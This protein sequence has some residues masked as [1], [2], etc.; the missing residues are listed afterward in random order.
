MAS[1]ESQAFNDRPLYTAFGQERPAL[2]YLSSRDI[3]LMFKGM[4]GDARSTSRA[5]VFEYWAG[6]FLGRGTNQIRNDDEAFLYAAR[7][8]AHLFGVPDGAENESDLARNQTLRWAT[9]AGV[10][11]NCDDRGQWNRGFTAD[12]EVRYRGLFAAASF[13]WFKNGPS[14]GLG[15]TLGY[16]SKCSGSSTLA[17][18]LSSGASVQV[19]YV[20]PQSI[21]PLQ[22]QAL[23]V[24]FRADYVDPV[25]P[26]EGFFGGNEQ[27]AGYAAPSAY[28]DADNSPTRWRLTFG[29]NW[30]P[31][32]RQT[33]RLSLN[34]QMNRESEHVIVA[35]TEIIGI[36]NDVLWLQLTAAL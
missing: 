7:V 11:T 13:V 28:S 23:E 18:H 26:V 31:T 21:F 17:T 12:S 1:D 9:G 2:R 32:G 35:G 8:S 36:L 34:Y 25:S 5:L 22:G 16:G 29:V 27:T 19:Q 30:F 24:L 14:S 33:I 4:V 15:D 20:L 3:G 10:Y 6:A